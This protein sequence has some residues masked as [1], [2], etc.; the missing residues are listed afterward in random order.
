MGVVGGLSLF[1]AVPAGAAAQGHAGHGP[2]GMMGKGHMGHMCMMMGGNS[3]KMVHDFCQMKPSELSEVLK[4][5][6]AEKRFAA[7][8]AIGEKRLPLTE[9]LIGLLTDKNELV[10]QAAR[11]SLILVSYNVDVVKKAKQR[12]AIARPVD[13]GPA[14]NANLAVQKKAILAWQDWVS[15]NEKQ[16]AKLQELAGMEETKNASETADQP[17]SEKETKIRQALAKLSKT[18]RPLAE[19]QKFCPVSGERLGAMGVPAKV[20]I[21]GQPVFL[22][23]P[24]CREAA[25]AKPKESLSKVN[26]FKAKFKSSNK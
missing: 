26:E 2:T 17:N 20:T 21:Q 13:F 18:D 15:K 4:S 6:Q 5:E 8:L 23:C 7:A 9:E 3:A 10:R 11:R 12:G 1:G 16:L 22:C 19:A 25:L 24:G 14:P